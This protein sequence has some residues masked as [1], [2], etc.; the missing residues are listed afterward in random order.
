MNITAYFDGACSP[1]NPG[2]TASYGA[3]IFLDGKQFWS[4]AAIVE[5][6]TGKEKLTSNNVAEYAGFLAVAKF[7][8][9]E[10]LTGEP[11]ELGNRPLGRF[12]GLVLTRAWTVPALYHPSA[13]LPA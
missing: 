10:N 8:L 11:V 6:P 7:L 9:A 1:T 4:D 5:M 12:S 2:G 3:V 13:A